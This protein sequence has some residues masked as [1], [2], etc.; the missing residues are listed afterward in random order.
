MESLGFESESHVIVLWD[1]RFC[2][3]LCLF[4]VWICTW[5]N[6]GFQHSEYRTWN[7]IIVIW[8]CASLEI[9]VDFLFLLNYVFLDMEIKAKGNWYWFFFC[10]WY[11]VRG[12]DWGLDWA[13]NRE[14]ICPWSSCWCNIWCC[15][16][17][18]GLW[19]ILTSLAIRWIRH[20]LYSLLGKNNISFAFFLTLIYIYIY[21]YL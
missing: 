1:S 5:P 8:I 16:F 11:L 14:W 9:W 20:W 12:N 7:F 10:S 18:W 17:Y 13:R 19:I 6:V 2:L 21:L 4:K 3:Y 15:F